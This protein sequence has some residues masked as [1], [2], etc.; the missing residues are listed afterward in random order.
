MSPSRATIEAWAASR[1]RGLT[2]EWAAAREKET[3][4]GK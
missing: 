3:E 4:Y 1:D 2:I